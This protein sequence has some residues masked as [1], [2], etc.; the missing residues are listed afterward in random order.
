MNT[1]VQGTPSSFT[2]PRPFNHHAW[3]SCKQDIDPNDSDVCEN[4]GTCSNGSF[5][6]RP[7]TKGAPAARISGPFTRPQWHSSGADPGLEPEYRQ[8]HLY[9]LRHHAVANTFTKGKP[10]KKRAFPFVEP[11][12]IEPSSK[13]PQHGLSTCVASSLVFDRHLGKGTPAST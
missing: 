8:N 11:E 6:L 1:Q 7:A 2:H 3:T 4:G 13:R 10:A 9:L 12:G 5:P